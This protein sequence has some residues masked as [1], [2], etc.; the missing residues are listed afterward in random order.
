M[1]AADRMPLVNADGDQE[2]A[3]LPETADA[4]RD[5]ARL[6]FDD[7]AASQREQAAKPAHELPGD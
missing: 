4:R 1:P 2:V 6:I 5:A 3:V 7:G